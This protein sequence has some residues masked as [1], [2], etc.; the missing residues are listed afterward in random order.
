MTY[1]ELRA[2]LSAY[3]KRTDPETIANEPIALDLARM[4]VGL[5]FFP[6]EAETTAPPLVVT[7]GQAPLPPNF[8]RAVA[9][10][11]DFAYMPPR[12]WRLAAGDPTQLARR[13][14]VYGGALHVH[15][16]LT[17]VTMVY[18]RQPEAITGT[19]SNWLS[20]LYPTVWLHAARAEQYRFIEDHEGAM[21]ADSYWRGLAQE[22][23]AM[24]EITRQAGGPLRMQS[25]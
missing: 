23:A 15:P 3:M 1:D 18:N 21:G 14:T 13:F 12:A 2:A 20:E 5:T 4:L 9:V 8:G 17:E 10:G 19:G 25:R 24:S 11:Q 16:G 22:L 6:H 7:D